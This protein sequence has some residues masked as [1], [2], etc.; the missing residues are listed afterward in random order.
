MAIFAFWKKCQ[1]FPKM[2]FLA[3]FWG[4]KG[5]PLPH[6]CDF[7]TFWHLRDQFFDPFLTFFSLLSS[8]PELSGEVFPFFEHR[9]FGPPKI[10]MSQMCHFCHFGRFLAIFDHFLALFLTTFFVVFCHFPPLFSCYFKQTRFFLSKKRDFFSHF[11]TIFEHFLALFWPLFSS[12]FCH[13][14][15][16]FTSNFQEYLN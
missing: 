12:F 4:C 6:F 11:L 2:P 15:P 7:G 9:D 13:F 5:A 14:P 10:V 8:S 3:V 1:F 16:L